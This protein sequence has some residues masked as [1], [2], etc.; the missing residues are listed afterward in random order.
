[1][2]GNYLKV[3]LFALG[4]F[5]VWVLFFGIRLMGYVDSIQRFGLER[6]ACGTDGCS[7]PTMWL[8]V[9]WVAVMFVGPLLGALAWL[10][11]WHVRRK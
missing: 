1:M 6:T 4:I 5:I 9:V 7:V 2:K 8:D 11:I 10:I 3:V